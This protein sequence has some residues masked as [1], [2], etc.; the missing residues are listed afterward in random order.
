MEHPEV[1]ADFITDF[2]NSEFPEGLQGTEGQP[3]IAAIGTIADK[4]IRSPLLLDSLEAASVEVLRMEAYRTQS[5]L[6]RDS[7]WTLALVLSPYKQ[8]VAAICQSVTPTADKTGVVDTVFRSTNGLVGINTN[9]FAAA[10]AIKQLV[11]DQPPQCVLIMGTGASSRSVGVGLHDIYPQTD[12]AFMGRSMNKAERV[13]TDIG[14]GRVLGEGPLFSPDLVI[15]ATTVGQTDD[16]ESL[17]FDISTFL[18]SGVRYFDLNNR[19]SE[20]QQV[21]KA[22]GC[23]VSSGVPMQI[24]TN[25]LRV[26]ILKQ[27][28]VRT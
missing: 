3:S 1:T 18:H 15:N 27:S 21:A 14:V 9:A 2:L 17:D 25:S 28:Q 23:I 22:S 4:A 8:S 20:L 11:G 5:D 16:I 26:A 24:L 19:V 10:E 7:R 13:I 12:L 6:S